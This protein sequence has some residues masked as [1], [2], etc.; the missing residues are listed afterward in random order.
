ML[1]TPSCNMLAEVAEQKKKKKG[2]NGDIW[3]NTK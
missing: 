3:T 2:K 1:T